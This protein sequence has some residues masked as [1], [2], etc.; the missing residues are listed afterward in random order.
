MPFYS[1]AVDRILFSRSRTGESGNENAFGTSASFRCGAFARISLRIEDQRIADIRYT[2]NGCGWM[3][4]ACEELARKYAGCKLDQLHGLAGL[5]RQFEQ[6]S[7]HRPPE[8]DQCVDIAREAIKAALAKHR[9][10]V[11]E[12]FRGESELI[13]TCFGISEETIEQCIRENAV[14]TVPQLSAL[15]RAGSGCG[16]C[17]ML[18]Q[19]LIDMHL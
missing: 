9:Q 11:V 14:R 15:C 3:L 12:E 17:T 10:N 2:T 8:R 5:D 7:A 13:C 1:E 16:S 18:L 4:A 6:L 19:E